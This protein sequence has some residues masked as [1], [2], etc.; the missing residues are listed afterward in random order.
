MVETIAYI[1]LGVSVWACMSLISIWLITVVEEKTMKEVWENSKSKTTKVELTILIL[2]PMI[3]V[4]ILPIF[5]LLE[6]I[7][8]KRFKAWREKR[9]KEKTREID[10]LKERV[11][12]L[13]RLIRESK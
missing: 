2:L 4:V 8:Q 10:E 11:A 7:P 5:M 1:W 12:V 3:T 6:G 9:K 13:E